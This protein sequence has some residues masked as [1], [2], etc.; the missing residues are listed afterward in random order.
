MKEDIISHL[1]TQLETLHIKKKQEE[2]EAMFTEYY[3]NY[4]QRKENCKCKRVA[5]ITKEKSRKP[6]FQ[7]LE[8]EDGKIFYI[9][10]RRP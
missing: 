1:A 8:G 6:N 3:P 7:P 5:N 10:Q 2:A 4:R 9:F